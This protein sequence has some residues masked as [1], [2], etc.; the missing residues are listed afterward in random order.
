M[1]FHPAHRRAPIKPESAIGNKKGRTDTKATVTV[2][3]AIPS[4]RRK[5]GPQQA[6]PV[7]SAGTADNTL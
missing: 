4:E 6:T 1:I 5:V 7:R 2:A 3:V